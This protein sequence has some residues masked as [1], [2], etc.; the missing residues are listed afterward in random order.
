[1]DCGIRHNDGKKLPDAHSGLTV[2]P[3]QAY[4]HAGQAHVM[5]SQAQSS[6]C[7]RSNRH[8]V[9]GPCHAVAGSIV[10]PSQT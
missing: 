5:P 4:R 9:A 7:R 8:A 1:M 10:M 2:M 3:S 6:C